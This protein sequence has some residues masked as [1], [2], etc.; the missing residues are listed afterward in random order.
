MMDA[1]WCQQNWDRSVT[2]RA[3][4]YTPFGWEAIQELG[5]DHPW[6]REFRAI[7]DEEMALGPVPAWAA[8]IVDRMIGPLPTCGHYAFPRPVLG[9]CGAIRDREC[10]EFVCGCYTADSERK[11]L[12]SYYVYCLDAWLKGAPLE[13]ATAELALRPGLGKDWP[14]IIAA[15]Y[16][17]LGSPSEQKALL[18]GRLVHRLR[19]WI[20]TLIWS[21]DKRDRYMLD[22][23]SGDARGDEAR[24][25]AYGN[26]PFGDPYFAERRLPE[27]E[28]LA[29]QIRQRVPG[30]KR[31]LERIE[32]TWLCAPKAFR[33]VEK[34][35]TAIGSIGGEPGPVCSDDAP[36]EAVLQCEDTYPEV[37]SCRKWYSTF[38]AS[39]ADW[40][41][42]NPQAAHGLGEITAVK[43][44]L[45][46]ILRH[47]L[48]LYESWDNLGKL[49]G[50][51][52]PG[53]SGARAI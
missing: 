19:W 2:S 30:G 26:P 16:R 48:R 51:Q 42:G 46:R 44:W 25:G 45:V 40:L 33:Y 52:P 34:L 36:A 49:V 27:M 23:Y 43:H 35:I 3:W 50:A 38:M 5:E 9:I 17:V 7:L 12:M 8:E 24:F 22:V 53:K 21:D 18:V 37:A 4:A 1:N 41:G 6:R 29:A 15:I 10:P 11:A 32:S 39:L 28:A 13:V 31:L 47:K 14:R 20:K